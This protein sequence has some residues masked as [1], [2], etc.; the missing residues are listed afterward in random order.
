[1][2]SQP[3]LQAGAATAK[4]LSDQSTRSCQYDS[5]ALL[6]LPNEKP[7]EK[8]KGYLN[9]LAQIAQTAATS[10]TC[11]S[12]LLGE[13]NESDDTGDIAFWLGVG[14]Y[15]SAGNV[16]EALGLDKWAENIKNVKPSLP[17]ELSQHLDGMQDVYSFR[18]TGSD[19]I[20]AVFLVGKTEG[21][22]GGLI[23]LKTTTM[24]ETLREQIEKLTELHGRIQGLRQ[25]PPAILKTPLLKKATGV[26]KEFSTL[27][28]I[29][30]AMGSEGVQGALSRAGESMAADGSEL[31]T[32]V[33]RESRKRRRSR[34]L[35]PEPPY[36]RVQRKGT[37]L[38]PE[39][40]EEAVGMDQLGQWASEY[41]RANKNKLRIR[42]SVVRF[43]IPDVMTVYMT[44]GGAG[45]V[46]VETIRVFGPREQKGQHGQSGYAVYQQLTQQLGSVL[47]KERDASF[48]GV[49]GLLGVY[50]D[51]FILRCSVCGRVVS[52]EGHVPP[53]VR[54]Y[55]SG[56]GWM[57]RHVGCVIGGAI[58]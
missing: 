14:N 43:S 32:E 49:V 42:G 41:N 21:G 25:I 26:L 51:L 34:A 46:V 50:S 13:G 48:Q 57:G 31:G 24:T 17:S 58:G 33:R 28:E 1:M 12:I 35:S 23:A 47:E 15:V 3:Q 44:V 7:D 6:L 5:E 29:G 38:L 56:N 52:G 2:L 16:L 40:T 11:S 30:E 18:A 55:C 9:S 39:A 37:S 53:V 54:W 10:Q 27:K 19:S 8:T 20:V 36:V 45:R 22:W 4:L